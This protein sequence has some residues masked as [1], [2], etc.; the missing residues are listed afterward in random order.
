MRKAVETVTSITLTLAALIVVG[1][2]VRRELTRGLPSELEPPSHPE[3]YDDWRK[4]LP[5][6]IEIGDTKAP[7]KIV[8]F[9]DLECP[10]CRAFHETVFRPTKEEFRGS[11]SYVVVHFPLDRHPNAFPAAVAAECAARQGRFERFIDIAFSKQDSLALKSWTSYG[12]E[13]E[14]SDSV[15]FSRCLES[16]PPR[17]R[18]MQG[19]SLAPE[20]SD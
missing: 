18:V 13:A 5:V 8:Q 6:G 12:V 20:L 7:I 9:I 19:R 4:L 10:F 1:I 14:V 17:D 2:L 16:G 3:Y 15:A 11:V